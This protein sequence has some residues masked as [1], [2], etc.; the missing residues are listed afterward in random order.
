V[1]RETQ[2]SQKGPFSRNDWSEETRQ[3]S[4]TWD[5]T[6]D[7]GMNGMQMKAKTVDTYDGLHDVDGTPTHRI[8]SRVEMTMNGG[9]MGLPMALRKQENTGTLLFNGK[10]GRLTSVKA[11]TSLTMEM[12]AGGQR[13]EQDMVGDTTITLT[14]RV[15]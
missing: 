10:D 12:D 13:V 1:V 6:V 7:T 5:H 14:P 15:P 4:T 2:S 11:R 8:T 9:M 3:V